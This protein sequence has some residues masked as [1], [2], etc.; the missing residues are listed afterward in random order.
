MTYM[1]LFPVIDAIIL[2]LVM[3]NALTKENKCD[4][5]SEDSGGAPERRHPWLALIL[6]VTYMCCFGILHFAERKQQ[7]LRGRSGTRK[8]LRNSLV[9]R[10]C[11][12]GAHAASEILQPSPG[13]A[14]RLI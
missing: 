11:G 10:P 6:G 12:G 2:K 1:G 4:D 14:P 5:G 3:D 9:V 13:P 8:W 7:D